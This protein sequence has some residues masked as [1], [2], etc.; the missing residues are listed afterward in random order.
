MHYLIIIIILFSL[1]NTILVVKLFKDNLWTFNLWISNI[2]YNHSLSS[3]YQPKQV[4]R[5]KASLT[6]FSLTNEPS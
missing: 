3:L 2:G 6:R 5:V 4:K 1:F